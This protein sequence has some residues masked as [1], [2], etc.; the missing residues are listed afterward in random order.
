MG[1]NTKQSRT[2]NPAE[3]HRKQLHKKELKKNKTERKL[4][5]ELTLT[6]KDTT[7][8]ERDILHYQRLRQTRPLDKNQAAKLQSLQDELQHIRTAQGSQSTSAP[9]PSSD[10]QAVY[11]F[12]KLLGR[13]H[14]GSS[15]DEASEPRKT[16]YSALSM[17]KHYQDGISTSTLSSS[18]PPEVT[19]EVENAGSL[20]THLDLGTSTITNTAN[21]PTS[22]TF[23]P[24][25]MST[26]EDNFPPL[27]PGPSPS[28]PRGMPRPPLSMKSPMPMP[29]GLPSGSRPHQPPRPYPPPGNH[30]L[31]RPPGFPPGRHPNEW[32]RPRPRPPPYHPRPIRPIG[33]P[34]RPNRHH[35]SSSQ[36]P[37]PPR[38]P[39]T[40]QSKADTFRSATVLSAEPVVRDLQKELTVMVPTA[41]LR[42]QRTQRKRQNVLGQP[43]TTITTKPALPESEPEPPLEPTHTTTMPD[44]EP[45]LLDELSSDNPLANLLAG[46]DSVEESGDDEASEKSGGNIVGGIGTPTVTIPSKVGPSTS[47]ESA[48]PLRSPSGRAVGFNPFVKHPLINPTRITQSNP[49][50]STLAQPDWLTKLTQ[51]QRTT[52]STSE[53]IQADNPQ[54]PLK[55]SSTTVSP[56]QTETESGAQRDGSGVNKPSAHSVDEEYTKFLENMQGLM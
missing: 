56:A 5:R 21:E 14:R 34:V 52:P 45:K 44:E 33:P 36:Q 41:L 28:R 20:P 23:H 50:V 25:P 18:P 22:N 48:Q 11:G 40:L 38:P 53:E 9:I 32:G 55:T 30:E 10:Q 13:H 54:P 35:F 3:L 49:L 42:K 43:T 51:P 27:P 17:T 2:L 46:F 26:N 37:T 19:I 15:D 1:R 12:D 4:H 31:I 47:V 6:H 39:K 16:P 24:S 7:K 8:L 29:P